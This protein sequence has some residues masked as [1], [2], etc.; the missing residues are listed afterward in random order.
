MLIQTSNLIAAIFVDDAEQAETKQELHAIGANKITLPTRQHHPTYLR[1]LNAIREVLEEV[2]R[3]AEGVFNQIV[4]RFRVQ[5]RFQFA[6][7][8]LIVVLNGK[9]LVDLEL[10]LK[11]LSISRQLRRLGTGAYLDYSSIQACSRSIV[12]A[13]Q[14]RG[15]AFERLAS[16]SAA[17]DEAVS[18]TSGLGLTEIWTHLFAQTAI[19]VSLPEIRSLEYASGQLHEGLNQHG[20]NFLFVLGTFSSS[21]PN[22]P[23]QATS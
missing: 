17:L 3:A 19:E 18:P 4:G 8:M 5:V 6:I 1:L 16:V 2:R 11:L 9:Q 7:L 22:S 23:P 14:S 10:I 12:A 13:L 15:P 21:I 20:M